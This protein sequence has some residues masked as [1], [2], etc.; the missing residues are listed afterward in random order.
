M[1]TAACYFATLYDANKGRKVASRRDNITVYETDIRL[2]DRFLMERFI[3]GSIDFTGLTRDY[4]KYR[5]I[6]SVKPDLETINPN[7]R[8][9]LLISNAPK[10][11]NYIL[12]GCIVSMIA[13]L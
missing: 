4:G 7:Y 12:L 8:L 3:K 10:T 11:E 1:E 2:A 13:A 6:T 9:F 5:R